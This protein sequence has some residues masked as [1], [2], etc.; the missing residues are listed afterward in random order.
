MDN[1]EEYVDGYFSQYLEPKAF[2]QT[3]PAVTAD[4]KHPHAY[5]NYE[6]NADRWR[7]HNIA[8]AQISTDAE[9]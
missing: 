2:S 6:K 1:Y 7:N 5:Q 9:E 3:F 4:F 8:V